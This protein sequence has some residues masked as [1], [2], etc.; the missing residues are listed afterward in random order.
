MRSFI[1]S[2]VCLLWLTSISPAAQ[3]VASDPKVTENEWRLLPPVCQYVEFGPAFRSETAR[4]MRAADSTWVYM[5]HYC[6]AIVQTMRTYKHTTDRSLVKHYIRAAIGNLNFTI[7]RSRP[8]FPLRP[9]MFVRKAALQ[10]RLDN[11][12]GAA[13][14]ARQLITESPELPE[15]YIALA[16]VQLKAGQQ[17]QARKT[18]ELGDERVTDKERFEAMK[19][20]LTFN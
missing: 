18:L 6:W 4:R 20:T 9:D 2:T 5:H 11:L 15:G 13:E 17:A 16:N 1:V 3:A 8:G 19:R 7:N 14:T 12:I 10:I